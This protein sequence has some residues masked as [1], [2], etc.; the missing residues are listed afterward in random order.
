M[1]NGGQW[2][3]GAVA[4]VALMPV[5]FPLAAAVGARLGGGLP[6]LRGA[7]TGFASFYGVRHQG[8]LTASGQRFDDR[9]L[10]AAS[11]SLPFGTRVRVTALGTGR[12]VVVVITDRMAARRRVLDVS[13]RAARV[14]GILRQGVAMVAIRR[15][16]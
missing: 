2:R 16:R 9:E 14:L 12:S 4:A 11:P 5:F 6:G 8:H 1:R 13:R 7:A 15:V 10:T 3:R